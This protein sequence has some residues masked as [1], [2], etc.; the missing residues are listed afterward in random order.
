[1]C[2]EIEDAPRWTT[3]H[4]TCAVCSREWIATFCACPERLECPACGYMNQRPAA[5]PEGSDG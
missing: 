3:A 4:M 1:M 2:R 5:A